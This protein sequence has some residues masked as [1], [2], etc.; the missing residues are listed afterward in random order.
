M[1]KRLAAIR[2]LIPFFIRV[3]VPM[4]MKVPNVNCGVTTFVTT[5]YNSFVSFSMLCEV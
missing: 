3:S 4:C 1:L 2:T 5:V